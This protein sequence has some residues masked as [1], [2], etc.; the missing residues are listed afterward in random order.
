MIDHELGVREAWQLFVG[1]RPPLGPVLRLELPD[2]W[3]RIRA[4]PSPGRVA[5]TDQQK[6]VARERHL[7][8]SRAALGAS[9][10]CIAYLT[11]W[12]DRLR[13][14]WTRWEL[15]PSWLD[16]DTSEWLANAETFHRELPWEG[17]DVEEIV[18]RVSQDRL[19]GRVS[20]LSRVSGAVYCPYDGGA[21]LFF[22]QP[23]TAQR[24][25]EQFADWTE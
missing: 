12:G 18:N 19:G 15:P 13:G 11:A 1:G 6:R 22:P 21:D 4:L 5:V 2:R 10:A 3:V 8:V 23:S 16:A 25:R 20:V 9:A 17:Q 14:T 24:F 7:A